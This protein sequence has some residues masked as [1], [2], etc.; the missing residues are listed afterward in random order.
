MP[1]SSRL[2]VDDSRISLQER[3]PRH[4]SSRSGMG[5][6][7][8]HARVALGPAWPGD[9]GGSAGDAVMTEKDRV[10]LPGV[11]VLALL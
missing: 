3:G 4:R 6:P 1:K 10:Q 8:R 11:Q 2:P 5:V 9:K 7:I